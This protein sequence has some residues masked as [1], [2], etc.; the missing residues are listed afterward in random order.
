VVTKAA[1]VRVGDCDAL[2]D[3]AGKL[4][5]PHLSAFGHAFCLFESYHQRRGQEKEPVKQVLLQVAE[6]EEVEVVVDVHCRYH[7]GKRR[8]PRRGIV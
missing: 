5:G 1:M 3:R 8:A 2:R 7:G 4:G 6:V